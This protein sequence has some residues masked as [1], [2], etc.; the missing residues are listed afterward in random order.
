[1]EAIG[2][3]R[4]YIDKLNQEFFRAKI[5]ELGTDEMG[6]ALV[7]GTDHKLS[8]VHYVYGPEEEVSIVGL[9]DVQYHTHPRDEQYKAAP[10]SSEDLATFMKDWV[11]EV[12]DGLYGDGEDKSPQVEIVFSYY[13][14][15]VIT[16]TEEKK[17]YIRRL[18]TESEPT[19]T[20]SRMSDEELRQ[21]DSETLQKFSDQA[22]RLYR[23][24]VENEREMIFRFVGQLDERYRGPKGI[25]TFEYNP[26]KLQSYTEELGK[27][28]FVIKVYPSDDPFS[29]SFSPVTNKLKEPRGGRFVMV[30]GENNSNLSKNKVRTFSNGKKINRKKSLMLY[31]NFF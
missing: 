18:F 19:K 12:Y 3:D 28:G 30:P 6:G 21:L 23:K 15:Y 22:H 1:M 14:T 17:N 31:W 10:P 26:N 24:I 20:L 11:D 25:P 4:F 2:V 5:S 16:I 29:I 9:Y 8:E 13:Y 27:L 7:F